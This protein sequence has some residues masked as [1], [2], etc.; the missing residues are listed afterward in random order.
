MAE[1]TKKKRIRA[2]HRG[3][4]TRR[5]KEVDDLVAAITPTHP[6]DL[7]KL[8]QLKLSLKE[9]LDTLSKLDDEILEL[10][11]TDAELVADIDEAD[12]IKQG[13]YA[14]IVK[15]EN[16]SSLVT[17]TAPPSSAGA[18]PATTTTAA[19]LPKLQLQP[20][21]GELTSWTTFWDEYE[22]AIHNNA[23]LPDIDKFTYLRTLVTRS[24]KDAI[25]GLSLT[26]A[27]YAEAISTLQKRFG[28]KQQIIAKHM[29]IL[30]SLEPVNSSSNVTSL[31]R[32]YDQVESNKRGLKSLG[33]EADTYGTLL[34]PML[35][36]KLPAELR[37]VISRKV[38]EKDWTLD[39]V[40]TALEEEVK[41]RERANESTRDPP[42]RP[43]RE[44]P[45]SSSLVTGD[46][47][48]SPFCYYC[49]QKHAP[50]LCRNVV[51]PE[52]RKTVL[53]KSGRCFVCLKRGHVSRECRSRSR[54][55]SCGGRH[56][57]SICE[58]QNTQAPT[59]EPPVK[60]N[61]VK[62]CLNPS[63]SP[64][65]HS[66]TPQPLNNPTPMVRFANP[67]ATTDTTGLYVQASRGVLLQ[68]ARAI[69]FNPHQPDRS[70]E[71]RVILD[72]G[73][74]R[75]YITEQTRRSLGIASQQKKTMSIITFGSSEKKQQI[76]HTVLVGIRLKNDTHK[77]LTL[78]SVPFICEPLSVPP[79]LVDTEGYAYLQH[80][81]LA[82]TFDEEQF[83]PDV[84]IGADH[85]WDLM[86]GETI[87]GDKGPVAVY[88][89]LGWVLSGPVTSDEATSCSTNLVTHV[90]GAS[91]QCDEPSLNETLKSFWELEALGVQPNEDNS[92]CEP[93]NTIRFKDGRYEVELPWKQYHP[94]LPDN[95]VLSQKR[96]QGL[97]KRLQQNPTLLQSYDQVI[98]DQIKM[99]IIEHAP[100]PPTDYTQ[101]HYLPH[102]A[103]V[104]SDKDTTKLRVVY[105]ASAKVEG[106]PSLNDCLLVG[107]KY[108]QKILDILLR[109]RFHQIAVIADIEKAFLMIGVNERD[110]D[111]L[112]F[113]WV[114]DA[115]ESEPVI[116][117][118]R[119]KR[120]MFGVSSSPFLLNSTIRYH[121]EHYRES[122]PELVE[123]LA[124]SF[125]VDDL[126][127]GDH[128]Q[129]SAFQLYTEAK[130]IMGEGSFNLRKFCTNNCQ[131]QDKID[132]AEQISSMKQKSLDYNAEVKTDHR[133]ERKVLGVR[134][135]LD[136]DSFI[137]DLREIGRLASEMKPTRR[138]VV[139]VVGKIYDPLGFLSPIVIRFKRLFQE[140][141]R[142]EQDWDQ[143]LEGRL[144]NLWTTLVGELQ[145]S[146]LITIPRCYLPDI[147]QHVTSYHLTG[148]C[149]ASMG[150]YAA[151]VYLL[152]KS[153]V[154]A[155]IRFVAAK[156]RVAPMQ[157]TL[158]IPRLELLSALLLARL[159]S[160]VFNTLS[161]LAELKP[162]VC[163]TDSEVARYWIVGE[164][165]VWKPFVQNR[166]VE[167]RKLVTP[168]QW[169]HC[170]GEFNPADLPSRGIPPSELSKNDM[171]LNGPDWLLHK[172]P[173]ENDPSQIP[174][175]C[176]TELTRKERQAV[177]GLLTAE[178]SGIA[179]VM[180]ID[181]YSSLTHLLSV[182]AQVLKFIER[183]RRPQESITMVSLVSHAET[184][185]IQESQ[186]S[187]ANDEH[188]TLKRQLGLFKDTSGIWRCR[189]RISNAMV[190][191]AVKHPILLLRSHWLTTLIVRHSH[192]RVFHN[193]VKETLTD[194]RA[195]YWITKARPLI[196]QIIHRC[197][198]CR[199]IEGLPYCAPPPPPL[200]PF[201]VQEA[202]PFAYSGVDFAGPLYVKAGFQIAESKVYICLFTCSVIRAVH[203]ELVPSLSTQTFLRCFKRFTARRGLPRRMISDNAKTFKAAAKTL[204][205]IANHPEVKSYL[206][207]HGIE[208]SFNIEKAPWWGGMFERLIK[209]TKR[210]LKKTIGKARLS[211]DELQTAIVEVE[212]ILNSRPISF[213]SA[214]DFEEPLTPSHLI[215]GRRLIS[216]PDNLAY[217]EDDEEEY[218][219]PGSKE[220]L[221][222]RMRHLNTTLQRFWNRWRMEYLTE[223]RQTHSYYNTPLGT[224][225]ISN[226]DI[227]IVH[228]DSKARGFWRLGRVEKTI[229]GRDG[230]VRGAVVRVGGRNPKTIRRP[231]QRLYPVE[232]ND[233]VTRDGHDNDNAQSTESRKRSD[234]PRRS[235]RNA[236]ATARDRILAQT[237]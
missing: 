116:Q 48:S 184:L 80:L 205:E 146:Q 222:K 130:R 156:T 155:Q 166:V 125:Y 101:V 103:V 177:G 137:F 191:Y 38:D 209:S 11:D 182:T 162:P 4:V 10:I 150:A 55:F 35:T 226:G 158:T 65:G 134:W 121:L 195:K 74:Q 23:T 46:N 140:L 187:L 220:V 151:V 28:S 135:N 99:G 102:H 26:S 21:N 14:A 31:R 197:V 71:V 203:L 95:Y 39:N 15:I 94:T 72:S 201:R 59:K 60:P 68:T 186:L 51:E 120:V 171:W 79:V 142:A 183:L 50:Q 202:P 224:R 57:T 167:I 110:R 69:V 132:V 190:S 159:I 117:P 61:P 149:D 54:C 211:Y 139:S 49:N 7:A 92:I 200:P 153:D 233:Q 127:T 161:P 144:L 115:N 64:F 76:C 84:L 30:L 143:P 118:L 119:F 2:G 145:Q 114:K 235:K 165:K 210:C 78:L 179:Q 181:E 207:Q 108:N 43:G 32:L 204:R 42:R 58:S 185:W 196:K 230:E 93:I 138:N 104:R 77:E 24:A 236:A 111:A 105:D 170:P 45:T 66:G 152:V 225:H 221:T 214:D 36:K 141:C 13:I 53:R 178:N 82:D 175:E 157:Q 3:V 33:V 83:Q 41:A 133:G 168:C 67:P 228:H 109:F 88:T 18:T 112:R 123:K 81:E 73:S 129:E 85:Y 131:L 128:D 22:S 206:S 176:L 198:L 98:Q 8:A 194:L 124:N 106:K 19:R 6:A 173:E 97:L 169:K 126:V 44:P 75:S 136:D 234:S 172:E 52:T 227:V 160:S 193:G 5:I 174:Q 180:N 154:Q 17:P 29:D 70:I 219:P 37:L 215:F 237:M 1:L 217:G 213:L 223:L 148:F 63:A 86:T 100:E 27:N 89:H 208:W 192:E 9:K 56:H 25:A 147:Q 87:R 91:V 107:P 16:S 62:S 232:F 12:T 34:L 189:G 113:L 188:H 199:K 47:G 90:L 20:F 96:L 218:C 216:L 122:Q 231:V 40:M 164:D 163:Y 229:P 212:A